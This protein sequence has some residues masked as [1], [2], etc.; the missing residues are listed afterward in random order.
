[1]ITTLDKAIAAAILAVLSLL[2]IAFGWSFGNVNEETILAVIAV[3]TPLI[4]WLVPNL[5]PTAT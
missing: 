5:K 4:V 2:T 1:M 3:A